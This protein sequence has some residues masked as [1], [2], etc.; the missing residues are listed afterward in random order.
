MRERR[1]HRRRL[2]RGRS[3]RRHRGRRHSGG[4]G[5]AGG[6]TAGGGTAGGGTAGGGTAGGGGGGTAGGGTAGGGT[7]GGGT[8][9]GGTAGG[10]TAGGGTA[11]GGTAGGGTAGGGPNCT[12]FETRCGDGVDDDCDTKTDCADSDC[13]GVACSTNNGAFTCSAMG[14]CGCGLAQSTV[15]TIGAPG[16]GKSAVVVASGRQR[17]IWH[18]VSASTVRYAECTSNCSTGAPVWSQGVLLENS[19]NGGP[20]RPYLRQLASGSLATLTRTGYSSGTGGTVYSECS[21]ASCTSLSNWA[22]GDITPDQ[23]AEYTLA[24]A[25]NGTLR[26]AAYQAVM[27]PGAR[28]GECNASCTLE[29]NWSFASFSFAP[30]AASLALLG[31]GGVSPLRHLVF[32]AADAGTALYAEC[33]GSCSGA[34]GWQSISL[35]PAGGPDLV[36]DSQGLPR[37]FFADGNGVSMHR[38]RARPC[39]TP[40]NWDTNVR[41]IGGIGEISAAVTP[42]G[43]TG[44]AGSQFAGSQLAVGLELFDGGYGVR[45]ITDCAGAAVTG[46][47]PSLSFGTNGA[48]RMGVRDSSAFR[49]LQDLP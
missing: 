1:G 26:T 7:A 34:G 18:D 32:S 45:L 38:C 43:R 13:V 6:G 4:G 11:G 10:G 24:F 19:T 41:I 31:D 23:V 36:L 39:T 42:D 28:Y 48:V 46:G 5:T 29:S 22:Q 27:A 17:L 37:V 8:A 2:D 35:P 15:A 21:S 49:Y 3:R 9:G 40:G 47:S 30:V 25:A 33:A 20:V 14:V 44:F 12:R 16:A